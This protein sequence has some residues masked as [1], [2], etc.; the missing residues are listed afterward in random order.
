MYAGASVSTVD[1]HLCAFVSLFIFT[2]CE[3]MLLTSLLIAVY[4]VLQFMCSIAD[5]LA[6]TFNCS[7]VQQFLTCT[8]TYCAYIRGAR[9]LAS[10]LLHTYQLP[11]LHTYYIRTYQ[12]T[13]L[14]AY[15]IHTSSTLC[16]PDTDVRIWRHSHQ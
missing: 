15:Y 11:L 10:T 4:T 5:S 12:L 16:A 7:H 1:V 6:K 2:S 8:S 13:V 9:C 3:A 14:H